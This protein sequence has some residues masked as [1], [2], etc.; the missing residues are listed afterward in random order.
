M[1]LAQ[2]SVAKHILETDAL[3]KF[4]QKLLRI[5]DELLAVESTCKWLL[6]AF[7]ELIKAL[8]V[9]AL[10]PNQDEAVEWNRRRLETLKKLC[11]ID[12]KHVQRYKYMIALLESA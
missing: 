1:R 2:N 4:L 6:V 7:C 5:V 11:E 3:N 12:Q 9:S 10:L 8:Q